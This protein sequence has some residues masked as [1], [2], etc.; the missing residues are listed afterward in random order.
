MMHESYFY[1]G[2]ECYFMAHSEL[3]LSRPTLLFLHGLGDSGISYRP[4]LYSDLI[5]NYNILIPDLLGC[6][7]SSSAKDY[8]FNHQVQGI[9]QHIKYLK[10]N[11]G[12][13]FSNF[14]LIA[15]SMGSI[16]ATLLCQS[17][18]K[19][20][21][22][23]FINVEGSITQYGS[24]IAE[25]MMNALK[26]HNFIKWYD[27]FKQKIIYEK[28][29][30]QF[31][32]IRPYYAS[33]EFCRP[34]AFIKNAMQMYEMSKALLGKYTHLIGKKYADL[35]IPSVYCYGDTMCKETIE[36]LQEYNLKSRYF[37]C[38]NHFLLSECMGEFVCFI[39]DYV[40]R[41]PDFIEYK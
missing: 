24:F 31:S 21:V 8:D 33:L 37:L 11:S 6:G 14:I 17:E 4:Y 39:D 29:A 25:E 5:K 2:D 3:K 10:E 30:A 35:A 12:I 34:E 26:S 28:L 7:K 16:H 38:K 23:A 32:S 41:L 40:R 20:M 18:F 27:H 15:H 22:K 19:R 13:K 1:I 9:E 36:F